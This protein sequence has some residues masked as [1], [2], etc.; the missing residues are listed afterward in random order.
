MNLY[1][2]LGD[3]AEGAE[4]KRN[5]KVNNNRGPNNSSDCGKSESSVSSKGQALEKRMK[6][7]SLQC[8]KGRNGILADRNVV[9]IG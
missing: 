8:T 5:D 9:Q 6:Q 2:S 1:V 4:N 7:L 3:R